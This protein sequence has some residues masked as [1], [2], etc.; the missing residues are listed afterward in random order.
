MG[1]RVIYIVD[2]WFFGRQ[3]THK[4]LN[5]L[6]ELNGGLLIPR[7]GP[8][9]RQKMWWQELNRKPMW[10]TD[11]P[12]R[13][14]WT[15]EA[16]PEQIGRSLSGLS[17]RSSINRV[18]INGAPI[19]GA[20]IDSAPITRAR[21]K[22]NFEGSRECPLGVTIP[23]IEPLI[24]IRTLPGSRAQRLLIR[25]V[26]VLLITLPLKW[27]KGGTSIVVEKSRFV[28]F[29]TSKIIILAR[30][31]AVSRFNGRWFHICPCFFSNSTIWGVLETSLTTFLVNISDSSWN[32]YKMI[33]AVVSLDS[34]SNFCVYK[35]LQNLSLIILNNH[36][37]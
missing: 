15:C 22:P 2:V 33:A 13:A 21:V 16:T 36:D 8:G 25:R 17:K 3:R 6:N 18:P 37:S 26:G 9:G 29:L 5:E 28:D 30:S 14:C 34:A 11:E 27:I 10:P 4:I 12:S 7:K 1:L 24:L 19:H 35:H 31:W 32:W 20:A 23:L